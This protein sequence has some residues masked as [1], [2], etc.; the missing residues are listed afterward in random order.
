MKK[1]LTLRMDEEAIEW[2]KRIAA[3]RDESV[4]GMT[5]RYYRN[6]FAGQEGKVVE[7]DLISRLRGSISTGEK[8]GYRDYIKDKYR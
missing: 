7:S 8:K 4:S 2:V 6:L 1:K 3:E 5:E